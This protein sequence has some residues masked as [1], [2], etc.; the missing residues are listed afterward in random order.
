MNGAA[1]NRK[2]GALLG[3]AVKT[4]HV[5]PERSRVCISPP[6]E[7]SISR[8]PPENPLSRRHRALHKHH[9]LQRARLPF[10]RRR[11]EEK[12]PVRHQPRVVRHRRGGAR[13]PRD[14]AAADHA[15]RKDVGPARGE[16]VVEGRDR[17][18]G[19]EGEGVVEAVAGGGV[20]GGDVEGDEGGVEVN[21]AGGK[22]VDAH[23]H[24]GDVAAVELAEE[25]V[26]FQDGVLRGDRE[27]GALELERVDVGAADAVGGGL[28]EVVEDDDFAD[29]ADDGGF[30]DLAAGAVGVVEVGDGEN[31]AGGS[32]GAGAAPLVAGEGGAVGTG[33]VAVVDDRLAGGGLDLAGAGG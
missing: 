12:V 26:D 13:V 9:V 11:V 24:G 2:L 4:R 27:G 25:E 1:N 18:D 10:N 31:L 23:L 30:G 15:H 22:V 8:E 7:S 19:A 33:A 17:D 28:I 6:Q 3:M 5:R 21:V 20:R 32:A 14:G 29:G 16:L